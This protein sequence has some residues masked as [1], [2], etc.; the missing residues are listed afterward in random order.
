MASTLQIANL[1]TIFQFAGFKSHV[2]GYLWLIAPLAGLFGQPVIGI[3]SDNFQSKYGRR[4]P[5]FLLSTVLG[6]V[7]LLFL[8]F[9]HGFFL[10]IFI[11][12]LIDIG[13][14]GNAQLSRALVLDLTR[15]NDRVRALSCSTAMAGLG[16][17]AGGLLPCMMMYLFQESGPKTQTPAYL[18]TTFVIGAFVYLIVCLITFAKT[19]EKRTNHFMRTIAFN[20]S[21]SWQDILA[22]VKKLPAGFW[23]LSYTLF[24]AWVAIF[25][26]WNYLN[27]DIAQTIL[28]MP[29]FMT[30]DL[31]QAGEYLAEANILT[32][33]YCVIL[34][35]ASMFF[36]FLIPFFN[37]YWSI[38]K[39][40]TMGLTVGG[41]SIILM[42]F[43]TNRYLMVFLMIFYGISWATLT[44]CPYDI[45]AKLISKK[46]HGFYMGII[47]VAIVFP[48]IVIGLLLGFLYKHCFASEAYNI[49]LMAGIFLIMSGFLNYKLQFMRKESMQ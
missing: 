30:D 4:R 48:Q 5:L 39:I 11:M 22:K 14:N 12:T 43:T 29:S 2:I 7:G 47:N 16:A 17:M 19:R 1:T 28:G 34:Q 40:F 37:K 23:K 26:I 33:F 41:I 20:Q 44:T 42:A 8:P 45:F 32:S 13:S 24:F 36:A 31:E 25:S 3:L 49:I 35:L 6:F 15:G 21:F 46:N 38:K 18:K 27:I 10:L 9:V